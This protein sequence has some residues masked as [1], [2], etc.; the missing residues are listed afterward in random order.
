LHAVAGPAQIEVSSSSR[1][2]LLIGRRNDRINRAIH[3]TATRVRHRLTQGR[4]YYDKKLTQGKALK[5]VMR[6]LKRQVS[7]AIFTGPRTNT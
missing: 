1:G 2:L 3:I 5:E 4:A 6:A 7:D